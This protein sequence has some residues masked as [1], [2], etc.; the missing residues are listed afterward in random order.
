MMHLQHQCLGIFFTHEKDFFQQ[1]RA[2]KGAPVL[3]F[4]RM[5]SFQIIPEA[6]STNK[7]KNIVSMER[8]LL[9]MTR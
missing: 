3:S 6:R 5:L 1:C 2:V 4:S 7:N 9:Q 8:A